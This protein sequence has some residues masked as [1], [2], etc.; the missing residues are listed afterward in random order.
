MKLNINKKKIKLTVPVTGVLLT[1]IMALRNVVLS[2]SSVNNLNYVAYVT[3]RGIRSEKVAL[4]QTLPLP[5]T[6]QKFQ[7]G[8]ELL[9]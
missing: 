3:F 1:F 6:S 4:A 8:P 5:S 2:L 9:A 7:I